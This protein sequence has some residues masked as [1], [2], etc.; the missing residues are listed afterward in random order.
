MSKEKLIAELE[1]LC[2]NSWPEDGCGHHV[3]Y[4]SDIEEVVKR[5]EAESAHYEAEPS[6]KDIQDNVMAAVKNLIAVKGRFHTE[7]AF[8]RLVSAYDAAIAQSAGKA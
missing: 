8:V 7:Q 3:V 6:N 4:A 5:L 1:E 2:L